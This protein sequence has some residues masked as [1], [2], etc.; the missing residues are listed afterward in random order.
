M[1]R[2]HAEGH[3]YVPPN[4]LT[5]SCAI[6][7]AAVPSSVRVENGG[8][9]LDL[10]DPAHGVATGQIAALYDGDAVVGAGVITRAS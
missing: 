3:L 5:R 7:R 9:T 1:T 10:E 2:I 8:F 6:A 4:G